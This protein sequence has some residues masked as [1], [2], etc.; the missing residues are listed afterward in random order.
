MFV[1]IVRKSSGEVVNRMGPFTERVAD[2]VERGV[3]INLNHDEYFTR[4]I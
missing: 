1:E 3:L 2:R 4:V